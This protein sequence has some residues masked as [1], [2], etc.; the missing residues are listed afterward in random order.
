MTLS[1][2][3]FTGPI[4]LGAAVALSGC[5]GSGD[6]DPKGKGAPGVP[7]NAMTI[8]TANAAGTLNGAVGNI[9]MGQSL[10]ENAMGTVSAP[11]ITLQAALG[12]A[13]K[14]RQSSNPAPET[15]TGVTQTDTEI[16]PGG[17]TV[18]LS[19]TETG[20]SDS[21]SMVMDKCIEDGFTTNGIFNFSDTYD[22]STT[23]FT[24]AASGNL[25]VTSTDFTFS[26]NG[27]DFAENGNVTS[28][29]YTITKLTYS[30]DFTT[31]GSAGGGY[32]MELTAPIVESTGGLVSC[33]ESGAIKITGANSTTA[34]LIYNG[35]G[36]VTIKA[37]GVVV[38][39]KAACF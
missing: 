38:D 25:S 5:A 29:T 26:F 13:K 3:Y 34:E 16:C 35:D 33:P 11:D 12:L 7:A 18:T 39:A 37:N 19:Y 4:L 22:T 31:N 27:F 10:A 21:G 6:D 36:T 14:I 15:A 28:G 9:D 2:K 23:A 8:T 24:L 32:L 20:T 30:I 1:M 17:G